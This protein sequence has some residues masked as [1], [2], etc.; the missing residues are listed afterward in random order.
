MENVLVLRVHDLLDLCSPELVD[1]RS[2]L[3]LVVLD[4]FLDLLVSL[5][6]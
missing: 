2:R 5:E 4:A 1:I 6:G 3:L